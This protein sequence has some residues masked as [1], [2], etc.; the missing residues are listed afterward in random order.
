MRVNTDNGDLGLPAG[1]GNGCG[2]R[3]RG[4][5]AP[6]PAVAAVSPAVVACRVRNS[7][8]WAMLATRVPPGSHILQVEQVED[9]RQVRHELPLR[10]ELRSPIMARSFCERKADGRDGLSEERRQRSS[11]NP[12]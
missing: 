11:G 8:S 3:A 4:H 6:R 7:A 5:A 9:G 2:E 12:S 10:G 1:W